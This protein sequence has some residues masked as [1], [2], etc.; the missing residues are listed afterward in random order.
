MSNKQYIIKPTNKFKKS[1][2]KLKKQ[3]NYNKAKTELKIVLEKLKNNEL[4]PVK[5]N[6]HL[7]E[8]KSKRCMGMPYT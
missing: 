7:L 6:N 4:L 5:Y 1:Y 3:K 8:P 2:A